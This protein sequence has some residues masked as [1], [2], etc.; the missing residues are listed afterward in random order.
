MPG[1]GRLG[2][3]HGAR[4]RLGRHRHRDERL[5]ED[6]LRDGRRQPRRQRDVGIYLERL[7]ELAA[8]DLALAEAGDDDD[9]QVDVRAGR[10]GVT[11]EPG[12]LAQLE[13]LLEHL[14]GLVVVLLLVLRDALAV[15]VDDLGDRCLPVLLG[16]LRAGDARR[17]QPGREQSRAEDDRR[18]K[19]GRAGLHHLDEWPDARGSA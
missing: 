11:V 15:E 16:C 5:V 14:A 4:R 3:R 18:T 8:A 12:G 2:G 9:A 7:V 10:H 1:R 6:V 19:R 13:R 17:G